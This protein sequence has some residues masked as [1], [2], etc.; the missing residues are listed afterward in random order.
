[1]GEQR[2]WRG[3][4]GHQGEQSI[5]AYIQ[6]GSAPSDVSTFTRHVG[7][8]VVWSSPWNKRDADA[9]GLAISMGRLTTDPAAALVGGHESVFELFYKIRLPGNIYLTPDLQYIR[10]PG[11]TPATPD[12]LAFGARIKFTFNTHQE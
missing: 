7:T 6:L 11:G 1:M 4:R 10:Y 12:A 9:L 8:G 2:V 5:A 3:I